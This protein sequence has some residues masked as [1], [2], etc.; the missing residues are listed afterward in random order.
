MS[1]FKN[2]ILLKSRPTL[3]QRC[4]GSWATLSAVVGDCRELSVIVGDC[5]WFSMI[6]G[7]FR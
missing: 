3:L 5:Q 2:I 4:I 1:P 6:V 7:C